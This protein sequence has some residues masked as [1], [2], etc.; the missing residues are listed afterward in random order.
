MNDESHG[1]SSPLAR[2]AIMEVL[3]TQ[4]WENDPP[5]TRRT[6]TRLLSGG[7]EREVSRRLLGCVIAGEVYAAMRTREGFDRG[8]FVSRLEL[9]PAM[10]WAEGEDAEEEHE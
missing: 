2:A 10:P 5:E 3:D 7:I 4:L 6:L 8:R 9:L 1:P